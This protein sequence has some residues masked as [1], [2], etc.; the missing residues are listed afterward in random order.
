MKGR[1]LELGLDLGLDIF[2]DNK[3][4]KETKP[5]EKKYGKRRTTEIVELDN[6]FLYRRAYGEDQLL[7]KMNPEEFHDG[8]SWHI[9]TGGNVDALSFLKVV[10]LHIPKI[11]YLMISTWVVSGMD[12]KQITEW[13]EQGKLNAIDLYLGEIFPN[14]YKVEWRMCRE[15]FGKKKPG[16]LAFFANHAKII[17]GYGND[18]K[19]NPLYF[20]I[21][22]S[23]NL[24]MNPRNE[25]GIITLDKGLYQFYRDYYDGI[26]SWQ[27]D[28]V[29]DGKAKKPSSN[30]EN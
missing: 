9:M 28:G 12:L 2:G 15:F 22:C 17:T 14:Q 1:S 6:K 26:N 30:R 11:D 25:Q 4:S 21:E 24:N 23:A 20:T 27:T 18:R 19:G 5:A 16:R 29:V 8:Q 3:F 7:E 13:H 10:M